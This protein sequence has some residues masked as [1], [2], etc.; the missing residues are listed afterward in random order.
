MN[1]TRH[2]LFTFLLISSLSFYIHGSNNSQS[3]KN[4]TSIQ[5]SAFMQPAD[6]TRPPT[7]RSDTAGI[8]HQT[9]NNH[10]QIIIL[11]AS[12]KEILISKTISPEKVSQIDRYLA[13]NYIHLRSN[14][15]KN[16]TASPNE[17]EET[18]FELEDKYSPAHG[19]DIGIWTNY[20]TPSQCFHLGFDQ[21]F[22][23]YNTNIRELNAEIESVH[24]SGFEYANIMVSLGTENI[25]AAKNIL[26][27]CNDVGLY[28]IDE[29][30]EHK[31]FHGMYNKISTELLP[32]L[33]KRIRTPNCFYRVI[34]YRREI[35]AGMP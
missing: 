9:A 13:N 28:F 23:N 10:P 31:V 26:E 27:N 5:Y 30:V 21:F 12:R 32:S 35:F 15:T 3:L 6:K 17:N 33:L 18:V 20:L 1:Y 16:Q 19:K 14:K 25:T 29:P 7:I 11:P 22:V 8:I 24:G 4:K 2:N 34:M